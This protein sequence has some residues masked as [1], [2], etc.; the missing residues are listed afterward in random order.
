MMSLMSNRAFVLL[1]VILSLIVLFGG[2]GLVW[3]LHK[4]R[5]IAW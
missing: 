4:G 5:Y 2:P 3:W 1:A